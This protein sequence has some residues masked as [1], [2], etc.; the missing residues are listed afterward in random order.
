MYLL[1][2]GIADVTGEPVGAGMMGYAQPGQR[3]TGIHLRQRARAFV[4][5]DPSSG[6]RVVFVVAEIAMFFRTVRDEVLRRLHTRFGGLYTADNVLLSATHTHAV[7]G[8]YSGYPLYNLSTFG[9]R[10]GTFDAIVDG[11]VESI[12]RAHGSLAPGRL[13]LNHGECHDA[14]VNRSRGA[15]EANPVRDK[16]FFPGA[17]DPASTVL[18]FERDGR[19]I[20]VCNW[21]ATHGTSLTNRN[22][23]ISGDNKG[24]AAY[25]WEREVSDVDYRDPAARFVAAFA[26]TNA[27]DMSP[28]LRLR[29]GTGPTT[30][31]FANA[32]II[33]Q[34]QFAVAHRLTGEPAEE[35]PVR[36]ESAL[37]HVDL[38]DVLVGPDWTSDGR[39]H[40]TFRASLGASFAAGSTEDGPGPPPFAEGVRANRVLTRM[41]EAVYRLRPALAAGQ[42]PKAMLLPCGALGWTATVLPLQLIRIGTLVLAALP[43]EPTIVAGLRLRRT[44][45][46]ALS[47]PLDHVLVQG[48][49]N[50]Y[51][52][53]LTTPEE[54]GQQHY[55][56]GHT[57]YGRWQLPACQQEFARLAGALSAPGWSAPGAQG[58]TRHAARPPARPRGTLVTPP[59]PGYRSGDRVLVRF[60]TA[61]PNRAARGSS[62]VEVQR[63]TAEGWRT[64]ADDGD[65]GTVVR[66]TRRAPGRW[67]AT[68]HWDIGPDVEDGEYRMYYPGSGHTPPFTV[69]A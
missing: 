2:A 26:Q 31:E 51:A 6:R 29:P 52:G 33:G 11:V 3:T 8:G 41:S 27:G 17:I 58:G 18:R 34:R 69:R 46:E 24:Y 20:G 61:N 1:G 49:A 19:T 55:E 12:E 16:D 30:D 43:L 39:P 47:V 63:R 22:T 42:A 36:L 38:S 9:F 65:W 14:S 62:H 68:V 28:N 57:M 50:D 48:Y 5:A 67:T 45:S 23:L 54:Y 59:S 60:A 44:L 32:R 53:Y 56:G 66:W 35:L 10:P 13:W 7:P 25:H 15:F 21:F 4:I 40:R 64:I 37:S